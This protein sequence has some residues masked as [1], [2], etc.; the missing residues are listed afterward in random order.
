MFTFF[1][2]AFGLAAGETPETPVAE[3]RAADLRD[4]ILDQLVTIVWTVALVGQEWGRWKM[5]MAA[6]P[7]PVSSMGAMALGYATW[8]LLRLVPRWR[9]S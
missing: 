4:N 9:D 5:G 6:N 2:G 8:R 3:R 1:K 7:Y